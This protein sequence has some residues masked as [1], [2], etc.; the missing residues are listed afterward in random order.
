[1]ITQSR[2]GVQPYQ[3]KSKSYVMS[4]G[5]VRRR[6]VPVWLIITLMPLV[7]IAAAIGAMYTAV[8]QAVKNNQST[9]AT[10]IWAWAFPSSKAAIVSPPGST[11]SLFRRSATMNGSAPTGFNSKYAPAQRGTRGLPYSDGFMGNNRRGYR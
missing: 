3:S 2:V 8:C 1:M 5:R 9:W 4:N 7:I 6:L 10:K 11:T